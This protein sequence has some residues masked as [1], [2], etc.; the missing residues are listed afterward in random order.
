MEYVT[1][2]KNRNDVD[3]RCD[4][5]SL[6]IDDMAF[7]VAILNHVLEHV[8]HRAALVELHRVLRPGGILLM[9]FPVIWEWAETYA[10]PAVASP[11]QR[12]LHFG[13]HDHLRYFGRDIVEQIEQAGFICEVIPSTGQDS[14]E[15]G[16]QRGELVFVARKLS[17][18]RHTRQH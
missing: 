7:D 3:I 15:Y 1:A 11:L 16:L 9:T 18:P 5:E 14:A 17:D 4:I 13:L 6:T 8:D 10:D 2:D 12:D